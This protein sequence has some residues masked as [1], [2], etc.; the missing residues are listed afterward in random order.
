ML[1][2]LLPIFEVAD[3]SSFFTLDNE[4]NYQAFLAVLDDIFSISQHP[5]VV[6]SAVK[7]FNYL[8]KMPS[9]QREVR[10]CFF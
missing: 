1:I 10:V 6:E 3:M 7:L 5:K 4:E 8:E 2:C 9:V